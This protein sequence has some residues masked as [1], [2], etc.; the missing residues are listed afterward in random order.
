MQSLNPA[1]VKIG[2][3]LPPLSIP[4]DRTYIMATALATRDYQPVHHDVEVARARGSEDVF[5]NILTSQGLVG[6]FV[7]D[8]T[9]PNATL[10]KIAIRL[11]ASNYPGDTM[12]LTGTVKDK[13]AGGSDVNFDIDVKGTNSRGEHVSGI[14]TVTLPTEGSQR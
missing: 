1:T 11:G 10:R 4:L 6:R 12:V 7:T 14:V 5:M 9:G 13:R 2:D 8:W 3:A